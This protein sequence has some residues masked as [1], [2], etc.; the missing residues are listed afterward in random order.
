MLVALDVFREG[1]R[2]QRVS[3]SGAGCALHVCSPCSL[4]RPPAVLQVQRCVG[5]SVAGLG[6]E[7]AGTELMAAVAVQGAEPVVLQR[8]L[9]NGVRPETCSISPVILKVH[10]V[11]FLF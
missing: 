3:R 10:C 5:L 4:F 7:F 9:G 2:C 6:A 11:T 8:A 1:K